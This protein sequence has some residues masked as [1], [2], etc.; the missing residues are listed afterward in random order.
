MQRIVLSLTLT[1]VASCLQ[2]LAIAEERGTGGSI[3]Q[4]AVSPTDWPWWRGPNRDGIA[5]AD[6]QPPLHWNEEENVLWKSP[7]PG[8]GHGSATVVGNQVLLATADDE[9]ETQGVICY[10]RRTGEPLWHTVVHSGNFA[11]EGNPK[12]SH[13]SST[14]ACHGERLFINFL[15]DGAVYTTALNRDGQQL[16]QTK[17]SDFIV[18][19][20]FGSSPALYGSLVLVSADNKG[21]GSI[22]ALDQTTGNVIWRIQR[23]K[24][25]NYASPIVLHVA[26]RDQLLFT[27]CDLVCGF[28]PLTGKK[29]WEIEGSTTECVTS[30]VSDGHLVFTSGGYPKNHISAVR[31]DG[32]AGEIVWENNVRVYVPSMLVFEG[33]LYTIADAGIA[34]CWQCE[35]GQQIWKG[36]LGGNFSASPVLVGEQIFATNE[37]GQTFVFKANPEEFELVAENQLGEHVMATPTICGSRIYMRVASQSDGQRRETLFCLGQNK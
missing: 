37:S 29:L 17:I 24:L 34:M 4:L 10:D 21:G 8:R 12:S 36:R 2:S 1:M 14:V 7:V 23:P 27:G 5:S 18:H 22:A 33:Y 16:W 35:T 31:S 13:A 30:T 15:N 26:G 9:Q 20:G 25:A 11:E 6:Q 28:E 32:T 19:Q 3:D